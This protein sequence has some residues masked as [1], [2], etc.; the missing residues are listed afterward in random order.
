V[1]PDLRLDKKAG[2]IDR[3]H[4]PLASVGPHAIGMLVLL[5]SVPVPGASGFDLCTILTHAMGS[6]HPL[7]DIFSFSYPRSISR[8]CEAG[9]KWGSGMSKWR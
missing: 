7:I 5:Y 2:E 1:H 4:F 6:M 8:F 9:R 3:A